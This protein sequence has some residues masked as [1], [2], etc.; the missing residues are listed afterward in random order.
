[1]FEWPWIQIQGL[2]PSEDQSS[3]PSSATAA[4]AAT[5]ADPAAF[6]YSA[7]PINSADVVSAPGATATVPPLG[8]NTE[9]DMVGGMTPL[10]AVKRTY[11]PSRL[12]RARTHGFRARTST[13][14]GR[15]TLNRRRAKGRWTL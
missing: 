5:A 8:G 3:E 11:Q 14:G 12:K 2:T 7:P 1:V 10:L 13:S 4:G 15:R 6:S 9:S